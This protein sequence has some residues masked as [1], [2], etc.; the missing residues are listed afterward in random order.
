MIETKAFHACNSSSLKVWQKLLSCTTLCIL[1]TS[2]EFCICQNCSKLLLKILKSLT[3]W[4]QSLYKISVTHLH[5]QKKCN[6][7][8]ISMNIPGMFD[9]IYYFEYCCHGFVSFI[10][11]TCTTTIDSFKR[12][13]SRIYIKS[14]QS[15]VKC[16]KPSL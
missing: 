5:T 16:S 1:G 6:Y 13:L 9:V 11:M 10:P 3:L 12:S 8:K 4:T 2:F 14:L 15:T 7:L